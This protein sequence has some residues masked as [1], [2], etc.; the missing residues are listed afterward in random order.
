MKQ[1]FVES[2]PLDD[3]WIY[4][5][6]AINEGVPWIVPG[7]FS[8]LEASFKPDWKVFE[9][10]AGG[11]TVWFAQNCAEVASVEVDPNWK[12]R[13]EKVLDEK[14]LEGKAT[15]IHV[16]VVEYESNYF[17]RILI[18]PDGYFDLV[19]VDGDRA[20]RN[21]CVDVS[22]H[23]IKPG[24]WLLVDNTNWSPETPSLLN[25]GHWD[26]FE[27]EALPF[28]WL[29][30][31]SEWK[32]TF[33][34]KPEN[35]LN[36]T[37]W[38]RFL[39]PELFTEPGGL[40]YIGASRNRQQCLSELIEAGNQIMILE[41]WPDNAKF[42]REK[43]FSVVEGDVRKVPFSSTSFDYVF[44]WHGPEHIKKAELGNTVHDLERLSRRVVLM[45][46]PWGRNRQ[47]EFDGNPFERH[48]SS[49]YDR[50][51]RKLGCE[52]AHLGAKNHPPH[53]AIIAWK[54]IGIS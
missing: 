5:R 10:G 15:V 44:W 3:D 42:L 46:C 39:L 26:A 14:D 19:Y 24:G 53:S 20:S 52:T 27:F 54:R 21:A 32:T 7:A 41:I 8:F 50:D 4:G 36:H 25:I 13:V 6:T 23:K 40:L 37:E 29:D 38:L 33:F 30:V 45:A 47:G 43:G 51:F 48:L 1:T 31:L 49:L 9:W 2:E 22:L 11:S 12:D 17:D 35:D 34:R 18:F 16:P 28:K